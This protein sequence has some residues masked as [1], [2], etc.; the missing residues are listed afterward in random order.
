MAKNKSIEEI[1][2]SAQYNDFKYLLYKGIIKESMIWLQKEFKKNQKIKE[3]IKNSKIKEILFTS[4]FGKN[5]AFRLF[6]VDIFRT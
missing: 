4:G 5:N 3:D 6:Y 2:I 1:F